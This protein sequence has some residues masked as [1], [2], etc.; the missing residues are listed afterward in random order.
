[1]D[2]ER[3]IQRAMK[4]KKWT[5]YR[6]AAETEKLYEQGVSASFLYAWGRGENKMGQDN[7]DKVFKALGI[8]KNW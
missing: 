8:P 5:F 4:R 7:I 1:M 2:I 6:L 3:A